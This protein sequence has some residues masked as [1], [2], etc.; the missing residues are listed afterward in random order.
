ME[1]NLTEDEELEYEREE[2]KFLQDYFST[3]IIGY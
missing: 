3:R 2:F 1:F